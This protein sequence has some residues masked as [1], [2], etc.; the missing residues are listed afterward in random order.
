MNMVFV[1]AFNGFLWYTIIIPRE[2]GI[3][4]YYEFVNRW[5]EF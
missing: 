1:I 2:Y 5:K 4:N 3:V